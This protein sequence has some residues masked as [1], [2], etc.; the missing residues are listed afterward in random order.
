MALL[1][2]PIV[3]LKMSICQLIATN[4]MIILLP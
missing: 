3:K 4:M 2:K 1:V